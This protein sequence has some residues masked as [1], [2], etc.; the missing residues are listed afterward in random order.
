MSLRNTMYIFFLV[1]N[2][3]HY[4]NKGFEK[5]LNKEQGL[6]FFKSIF[7]KIIWREYLS[8]SLSHTDVW[9]H[10]SK[11]CSNPSA[12]WNGEIQTVKNVKVRSSGSGQGQLCYS[13]VLWPWVSY[14]DFSKHQFP[15]LTM[16]TTTVM[17]LWSSVFMM[18][19]YN[20]LVNHMYML[21]LN[22][23]IWSF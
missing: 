18:I 21:A 14:F 17:M 1:V 8:T 16:Y 10:V 13:Q 23:I 3:I 5:T 19:E 20:M 2:N 4:Y 22:N 9:T 11:R 7:P 6:I 12:L 15:Y